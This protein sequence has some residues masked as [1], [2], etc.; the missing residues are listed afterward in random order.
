[1]TNPF[2]IFP[3]TPPTRSPSP[4]AAATPGDPP[5]A[6]AGN[7]P[8]KRGALSLPARLLPKASETEVSTL[9]GASKYSGRPV[10][11]AADYTPPARTVSAPPDL[12]TT[13]DR[14]RTS[15]SS[16]RTAGLV[17]RAQRGLQ[18][19]QGTR[20]ARAPKPDA[21]S[22]RLPVT[23]PDSAPRYR[24]LLAQS[25][26]ATQDAGAVDRLADRLRALAPPLAEAAGERARYARP[27]LLAKVLEHT[28]GQDAAAALRVLDRL[29]GGMRLGARTFAASDG[30]PGARE[31]ALIR[32]ASVASDAFF[33]ALSEFHDDAP[34]AEIGAAWRT[35]QLLAR[36]HAGFDALC[37]LMQIPDVPEQR[38]AA[39]AFLQAADALQ[40]GSVKPAASPQALLD[41]HPID[42]AA[43]EERLAIKTLHGAA[44]VLRG[45]VPTPEQ[46]GAL[47][48]WR[49]GFR[50]EGPGTALDKTKARIGRFVRRVIPRVEKHSWRTTL[51]QMIGKKASPLSSARLGLQAA[52]RKSLAGEYKDYVDALRS[53]VTALSARYAQAEAAPLDAPGALP[54]RSP[55]EMW[56]SA[57]L[58]HWAGALA[59]ASP[60]DCVLTDD[61]LA[62]IGR[63]LHNTVTRVFDALADGI[64]QAT[65]HDDGL[66]EHLRASLT[67][68]TRLSQGAGLPSSHN[69]P[70][71]PPPWFIG[72]APSGALLRS[73]SPAAPTDALEKALKTAERIEQQDD[74]Q[75]RE[76][77]IEAARELIESLL[78]TIDAGG[79]LRLASG[80]AL[81]V[82]T[83]TL[84]TGLQ[85]AGHALAIPLS[86]QADFHASRKRQAV[87]EFGRGAHGRDLFIGTDQTVHAA[88]G[89]GGAIGYDI[90]LLTNRIR[91]SLGLSVVPIDV[92]RGKR[93]GVMFRAVRQLDRAQQPVG[94]YH[95]WEAVKYDDTATRQALISLSNWLFEQATEHRQRPLEREAIWNALALHCGTGNTISVGW[96]DQRKRRLRHKLRLSAGVQARISGKGEPI[97]VGP[98]ARLTAEAT[99]RDAT[100]TRETAG[101]MRLEQSVQGHGGHLTLRA[102]L[103]YSAG[104]MFYTSAAPDA[105]TG[106]DATGG[107]HR[108]TQG[109]NGG[110]PLSWSK[111]FAELGHTVEVRTIHLNGRLADRVCYADKRYKSGTEFLALIRTRQR[112]WIDMLARKPGMTREAAEQEFKVF[113]DMVERHSGPN[114]GYLYRE[115]LKPA[116]A[117][118]IEG[119]LDLADMHRAL[120][121]DA[122]AGPPADAARAST[123][124]GTSPPQPASPTKPSRPEKHAAPTPVPDRFGIEAEASAPSSVAGS[125]PPAAAE[126]VPLLTPPPL[127]KTSRLPDKARK[128]LDKYTAKVQTAQAAGLTDAHLHTL[129]TGNAMTKGRSIRAV[130]R[131]VAKRI[132]DG[133]W[134][135]SS[136]PQTTA[137]AGYAALPGSPLEAA[138]AAAAE[139]RAPGSPPPTP[140]IARAQST[141]LTRRESEAVALAEAETHAQA[142]EM[143]ADAVLFDEA[144]WLPE[145][146][147]I[148]ENISR[149]E[150]K[151]LSTTL[152]LYGTSEASGQRDLHN[153]KFG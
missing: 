44:A 48:A 41:K 49:Q 3:N 68:L 17:Q 72:L 114:I 59:Q 88:A 103:T 53:A 45:K 75:L 129:L 126:S 91:A 73:W 109:F 118:E 43:P 19:L 128:L 10:D 15:R 127:R 80:S 57:I 74:Q 18:K 24:Q 8:R 86:V 99:S 14:D 139:A 67:T 148:V 69:S 12:P 143:A 54:W 42:G 107:R 124:D 35:A 132:S 153:L 70:I 144:S 5:P 134:S 140:H 58:K 82:N 25:F 131:E 46:A 55:Q 98:S 27:M 39:H 105:A 122:L 79:K 83:G 13:A 50:E 34:A 26:A 94:G 60:R 95:D 1:M 117:R 145:R 62:A 61:I 23:V 152:Q 101:I 37:S 31:P 36:Y 11:T 112:V 135:P 97:R 29:T 30:H 125:P 104:K 85:H 66:R 87:V 119:Q 64:A 33:D 20:H 76:K 90:R 147:A 130:E 120:D 111:Q 84:S 110:T 89:C 92:E 2:R 77:T 28:C 9:I 40:H 146:L 56:S 100:A 123:A 51:W 136:K 102:G 32:Q 121:V 106:S 71:H 115:R 63:Q 116:I 113:C 78:T 138:A 52:H 6:P 47:F 38:Q 81:G 21:S 4:P 142:C 65:E 93:V 149:R 151:G 108:I 150:N 22:T 96:V 16:A 133:T 137:P 7:A 141:G